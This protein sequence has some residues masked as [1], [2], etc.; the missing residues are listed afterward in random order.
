MKTFSNCGDYVVSPP[1]IA[2]PLSGSLL[3]LDLEH[4]ARV[5]WCRQ[6]SWASLDPGP[7]LVF[8]TKQ[9]SSVFVE[10]CALCFS[11]KQP[12]ARCAFMVQD[13]SSPSCSRTAGSAVCFCRAERA[14]WRSFEIRALGKPV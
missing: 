2:I 13:L 5:V 9:L 14:A 6:G 8:R 10:P 4:Q 1:V 7:L 12:L 3:H 11:S